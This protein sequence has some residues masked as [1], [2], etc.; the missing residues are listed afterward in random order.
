MPRYLTTTALAGAVTALLLTVAAPVAGANPSTAAEPRVVTYDASQAGEFQAAI[1]Q[2]AQVWNGQVSNVKL[3]KA[4]D[5]HA[6]VT[7]LADD[8]WPRTETTSLGAGTVWMGREAVNEGY[9]VPRIATHE[10]GHIFGLPDNRT[11]VCADLMSGHSAGPSC[12][13]DLPN[14][15]EKA[16]VEQNFADGTAITPQLFTEGPVLAAH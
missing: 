6:D 2:A 1:D 14:P 3:Q 7:V 9:F 11:G 15:Q 13:N 16:Q 4:T 12:Q 5:G 10:L 8:D